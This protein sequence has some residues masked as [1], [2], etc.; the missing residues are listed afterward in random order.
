MNDL[1]YVD[2]ICASYFGVPPEA[3][4]SGQPLEHFV[5]LIHVDDRQFFNDQVAGAIKGGGH[6]EAE[7]RIPRHD[8][9]RW[10]RSQGNFAFNKAGKPLRALGSIID[11]TGEREAF[12]RS[13]L[14]P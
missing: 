3:A 7:Y 10:V 9:V 11:I 4:A 13:S 12:D 2:S 6:F 14:A 1:S 5:R 8:R